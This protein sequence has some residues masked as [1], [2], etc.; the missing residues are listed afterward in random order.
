[1]DKYGID[2]VRGGSFVQITL[3]K[4]IIDNIVRRNRNA[5]DKCFICGNTDHF[6]KDCTH[7]ND[8][9]I[10]KTNKI[11]NKTYDKT[12]KIDN[13]TYDKTN[14]IDNKTY[15]KT[16][17]IDNKIDDKYNCKYCD[18]EF[19]SQKGCLGHE[20]LYCQ[21]KKNKSNSSSSNESNQ[22]KSSLKPV[23]N[24]CNRC[25][26]KGHIENDCY[27]TI[28]IN[29]YIINDVYVCEYCNKQFDSLKG[30]TYHENVYCKIKKKQFTK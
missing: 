12:N 14:K 16:N 24:N 13:K 17:K 22:K 28:D 27:A 5:T 26:R 8:D 2:N 11:D 1:M 10:N 3:D 25:H 6:A 15:D 18:K 4:T 30:V 19:N 23:N 9:K 21:S 20:N 29:N 7:K